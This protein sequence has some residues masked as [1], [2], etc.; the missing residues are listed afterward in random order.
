MTA[1]CSA[2]YVSA[3]YTNFCSKSSVGSAISVFQLFPYLMVVGAVL[4]CVALLSTYASD[5]V[6]LRGKFK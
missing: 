4:F 6:H 3:Y 2:M 1:E 5:Q